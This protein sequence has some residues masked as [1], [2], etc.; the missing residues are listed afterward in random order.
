MEL[1]S[2]H[3]LMIPSILFGFFTP[4]GIL[5]YYLS[6]KSQRKMINGLFLLSNK[7]L[8]AETSSFS[9]TSDMF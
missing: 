8:V 4:S 9:M 1:V 3:V 5:Y 2:L 7:G 6:Q